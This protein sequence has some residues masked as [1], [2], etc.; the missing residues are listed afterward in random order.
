MGSKL[1]HDEHRF[2]GDP[3]SFIFTTSKIK[4]RMGRKK[5]K[6]Y[7][8]VFEKMA[9]NS[10]KTFK[11]TVFNDQPTSSTTQEAATPTCLASPK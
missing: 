9:S 2:E 10:C 6:Y 1:I 8:E 7:L 5:G 4:L 3:F 11:P